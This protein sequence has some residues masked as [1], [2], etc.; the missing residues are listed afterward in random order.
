MKRLATLL[1]VLAL[2]YHGHGLGHSDMTQDAA[3]LQRSVR[4][5]GAMEALLKH[6][7]LREEVCCLTSPSR[8]SSIH[9]EAVTCTGICEAW[10]PRRGL[11]DPRQGSGT[12]YALTV[13]SRRG[14]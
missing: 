2:A 12:A 14:I 3:V 10:I 11:S 13:P 4:S 9:E 1:Q 5:Q 7:K 6:G 8:F